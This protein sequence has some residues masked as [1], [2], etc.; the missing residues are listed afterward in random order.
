MPCLKRCYSIEAY[1]HDEKNRLPIQSVP[2]SN[3]Y[4]KS[5]DHVYPKSV[6]PKCRL[7]EYHTDESRSVTSRESYGLRVEYTADRNK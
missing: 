4:N 3:P 5:T 7:H 1:E 6:A 2:K